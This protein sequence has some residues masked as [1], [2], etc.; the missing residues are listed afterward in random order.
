MLCWK[1]ALVGRW[2]F[3]HNIFC[4]KALRI[5]VFFLRLA[6]NPSMLRD[7]YRPALLGLGRSNCPG[8]TASAGECMVRLGFS[9]S[10]RNVGIAIVA[11][12]GGF[13][14]TPRVSEAS[15]GDYVH[16]GGLHAP[17]AHSMPDHATNGISADGTDRS[18]PHRPCQGPGCSGGSVPL[19]TPTPTTTFS[20]DRW[21]LAPGDT[22]PNPFSSSNVLAEPRHIVTD[23]FCLS[24]LRPPR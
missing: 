4:F 17:M 8:S 15:C 16:V 7:V 19:Q 13:L 14:L 20:I 23:G 21:A 12:L 2:R 22:L 9:R 3:R 18:P 10:V 11:L 1:P 24:I 5:F 6:R